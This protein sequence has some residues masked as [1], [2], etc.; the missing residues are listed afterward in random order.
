MM[1]LNFFKLLT[2][3]K[4][5]IGMICKIFMIKVNNFIIYDK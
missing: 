2:N 1:H 5:R 4:I 3:K